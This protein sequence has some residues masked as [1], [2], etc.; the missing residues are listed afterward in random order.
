MNK[1]FKFFGMGSHNCREVISK[2]E[3][4][5]DGELD[6]ASQEKLIIEINRCPACLEHYNIDIAFK[7][8]VNSRLRRKCCAESMKSEIL[9]KIRD[10]DE[11]QGT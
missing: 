7:E 9:G 6:D 11:E 10:F 5:I 1:I 8:F 3:E 2:V 4:L